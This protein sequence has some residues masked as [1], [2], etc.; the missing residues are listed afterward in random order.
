MLDTALLDPVGDRGDRGDRSEQHVGSSPSSG[1]RSGGGRSYSGSGAG[2]GSG[3]G[4]QRAHSDATYGGFRDTDVSDSP[5]GQYLNDTTTDGTEPDAL[6]VTGVDRMILAC[7]SRMQS[8]AEQDSGGS[9]RARRAR[10]ALKN[11]GCACWKVGPVALLVTGV[12]VGIAS[13]V[14]VIFNWCVHGFK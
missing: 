5:C 4:K 14:G 6:N 10:R 2:G 8:M 11:K 1:G 7:D 3:G 13:V 12:V 9:D